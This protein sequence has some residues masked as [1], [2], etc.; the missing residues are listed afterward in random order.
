MNSTSQEVVENPDQLQVI[1]DF[2]EDLGGR[3]ES[4]EEKQLCYAV[5]EDYRVAATNSLQN[6]AIAQPGEVA[7]HKCGVESKLNLVNA[8]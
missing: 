3:T 8:A 4:E 1:A 7:T 6:I 2:M 5:A